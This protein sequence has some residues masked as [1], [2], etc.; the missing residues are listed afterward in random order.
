[1][2]AVTAA[3][4]VLE[5]IIVTG[6]EYI[7]QDFPM[8]VLS[9]PLGVTHLFFVGQAGFVVKSKSGQLL[10][11]DLYLSDC[12]ERVEGHIGFK[13]LMPKIMAPYD[14]PFHAVI[15]SHPHF[16]HFDMDAI[17]YFMSNPHTKLFASVNCQKEM[18]RLMLP[19]T[20]AIYVKPGD[21]QI[22]GDFKL[23]FINCDHGTGAPDAVGVI[24]TV[25]GKNLLF[26]GDTCLRLDRVKEYLS[27]GYLD[28]MAAP[29]N[30]AFGNMDE[31]DCAALSDAL[32]PG[33]TV[34]CHF[35]MFA[36]HGGNPGK[37]HKIMQKKKLPYLLMTMGEEYTFA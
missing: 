1:M 12:V 26:A 10:G 23:T 28:F 13:R 21:M 18:K 2:Y 8:R 9:A 6:K 5:H 36:S 16:D 17:P 37:F 20:N 34:P 19:D 22:C 24:V 27:Q 33:V 25:D 30:G 31:E 35:G 32:R 4:K 3:E 11:M 14:L 29:I 15:A 7:M